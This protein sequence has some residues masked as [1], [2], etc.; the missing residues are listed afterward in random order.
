MFIRI[1]ID[2]AFTFGGGDSLKADP[3][4]TKYWFPPGPVWWHTALLHAVGHTDFRYTTLHPSVLFDFDFV[5]DF[6]S[7]CDDVN[8][9]SCNVRGPSAE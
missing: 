2:Y 3:Y 4:Y 7:T 5:F 8:H 6:V 1:L 9:D